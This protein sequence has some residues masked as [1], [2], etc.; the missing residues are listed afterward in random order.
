MSRPM[1]LPF[2]LTFFAAKK[3]VEARPTAQIENNLSGFRLSKGERVADAAERFGN[4]GWKGINLS[5][6]VTQLLGV[7]EP[8]GNFRSWSGAMATL[9]KRS[10]TEARR[11]VG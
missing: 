5:R 3:R 2:G 8:T 9:R 6:F 4:G 10:I 7:S 11:L 1:T